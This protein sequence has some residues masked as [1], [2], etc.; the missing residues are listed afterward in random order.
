MKYLKT[1]E[2]YSLDTTNEAFF[3]GLRPQ[4]VIKEILADLEK[5]K[6][7]LAGKYNDYAAS[8]GDRKDVAKTNAPS[9]DAFLNGKIEADAVKPEEVAKVVMKAKVVKQ[10]EN[11]EWEDIG[12]YGGPDSGTG[13]EGSY[14]G[15]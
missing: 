1:F 9:V 7:T 14:K 6:Q 4:A 15:N 3:G 12:A 11:G 13:A 8:L 2:S 10:K 5:E